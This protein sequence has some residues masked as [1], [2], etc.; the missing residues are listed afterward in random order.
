[1]TIYNAEIDQR[2]EGGPIIETGK[3]GR[4]KNRLAQAVGGSDTNKP[5][6]ERTERTAKE[7]IYGKDRSHVGDHYVWGGLRVS[8]YITFQNHLSPL[9]SIQRP[10]PLLARPVR[11]SVACLLDG[12]Y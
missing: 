1:M 9:S 6:S 11:L 2:K 4:W 8:Q 12:P 7:S 5:N 10:S 3:S